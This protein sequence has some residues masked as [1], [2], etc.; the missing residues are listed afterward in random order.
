MQ[1]V[2]KQFNFT[3][4]NNNQRVKMDYSING[5][6]QYTRYYQGNYERQESAGSY[7]EWSYISTPSGPSAVYYNN[8]GTGQLFYITTD[9]LDSP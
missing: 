8:N 2:N 6:N 3:Y 4:G 5:A 1:G 7:K 9:H